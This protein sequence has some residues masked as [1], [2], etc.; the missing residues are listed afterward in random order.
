[1]KECF[2]AI[3]DV[4]F[5]VSKGEVVGIV[6]R[7]GC[8]KS[9][10]LQLITGILKPTNGLVTLHGRVSAILELGAGFNPRAPQAIG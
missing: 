5:T 9:T 3:S 2:T 1:M 10:L 6:G 7:N 4:S 8:G